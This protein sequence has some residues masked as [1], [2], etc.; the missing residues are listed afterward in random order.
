[1]RNED[2]LFRSARPDRYAHRNGRSR[3]DPWRMV[4][5]PT[6]ARVTQSGP[7]RSNGSGFGAVSSL[8]Q[9]TRSISGRPRPPDT[10][11]LARPR[12]CWIRDLGRAMPSVSHAPSD[13]FSSRLARPQPSTVR[14]RRPSRSAACF[15][16]GP[17]APRF[18]AATRRRAYG[19]PRGC[20][21]ARP[22][23]CT[24]RCGRTY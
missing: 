21:R 2:L 1:M 13:A 11:P 5:S 8:A 4:P 22:D 18:A 24:P 10:R 9:R 16:A 17:A 15:P 19:I 6:S 12:R 3:I 20:G 14:V 7:A 23:P